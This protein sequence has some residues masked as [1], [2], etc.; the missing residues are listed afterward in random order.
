[1]GLTQGIHR[2]LQLRPNARALVAADCDQN[3]EAFGD[4]LG[5]VA[6]AVI[7]Y[8]RLIHRVAGRHHRIQAAF[9]GSFRVMQRDDHRDRQIASTFDI[10][11][12][13]HNPR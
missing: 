11:H 7:H 6:R 9:N 5:T 8:D 1:M 4:A 10:H 12:F 3:W 2:A 13:I